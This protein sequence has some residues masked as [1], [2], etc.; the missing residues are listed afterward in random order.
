MP[1]KL[2]VFLHPPE[3]VGD[4]TV[5]HAHVTVDSDFEFDESVCFYCGDDTSGIPCTGCGKDLCNKCT[6]AVGCTCMQATNVY[7]AVDSFVPKLGQ[8]HVTT[9]TKKQRKSVMH[10]EELVRKQDDAIWTT[11]QRRSVCSQS[12]YSL[13]FSQKQSAKQ[14]LSQIQDGMAQIATQL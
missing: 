3:L 12:Q 1:T 6:D 8:E 10:G 5:A 14:P 2:A 4:V 13:R 11:F 7:A 9:F